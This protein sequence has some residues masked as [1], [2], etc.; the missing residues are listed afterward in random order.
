MKS[1]LSTIGLTGILMVSSLAGTVAAP[2]K[3]TAQA[4]VPSCHIY[5]VN[6]QG[7]VVNNYSSQ[8]FSVNQYAIWRDRGVRSNRV[9]FMLTT[10]TDLNVSAKVGQIEFMTN[11]YFANNQGIALA[12]M[13]LAQ[14]QVGNQVGFTLNSG[15]SLQM[16]Q[17]NV[18]VSPGVGSS[19]GG[20][21][22]L[23]YL[24]GWGEEFAR[25]INGA[26]VLSTSQLVPNSGSGSY[27]FTDNTARTIVGQLDISGSALG[28]PG[29]S[30]R[31]T[32]AFQGNYWKSVACP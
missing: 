17:P 25:Y 15:A 26:E 11:S 12:K 4:A 13:D 5:Q 18:F 7:T 20:L 9:D 10:G 19:P 30:G 16:P 32:A 24:S 6:I 1:P 8:P 29:L 2:S 31:Y 27:R 22:G 14:V 3:A 23:G 28:N 21:G